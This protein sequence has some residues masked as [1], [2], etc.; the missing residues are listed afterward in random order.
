QVA[1]GLLSVPSMA[2]P[3]AS[4][5][6]DLNASPASSESPLGGLP[7][8]GSIPGMGS[9]GSLSDGHFVVGI[10]VKDRARLDS[11]IAMARSMASDMTFTEQQNGDRTIVSVANSSGEPQGAYVVTNNLLLFAPTADDLG[12]ALGVLDGT[13]PSLASDP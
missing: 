2:A 7:G 4:Q 6:P 1:I 9:M 13:T 8:M 11:L 12:T 10:G 5:E 3:G